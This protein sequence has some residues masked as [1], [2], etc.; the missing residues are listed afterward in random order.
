MK[1]TGLLTIFSAIF[2]LSAC[3]SGLGLSP[4]VDSSEQPPLSNVPSSNG[5][6]SSSTAYGSEEGEDSDNED[7]T[8]DF[9]LPVASENAEYDS[10]QDISID[11]TNKSITNNNGFVVFEE[12]ALYI[13]AGGSYSMS[14]TFVGR[15]VI[16][17][18]DTEVEISLN[19]VD[20]SSDSYCPFLGYGLSKLSI[21]AKKGSENKITDSRTVEGSFN[22]AIYCDSDLDIKGKG[23][24]II[25][26]SLNNG[27]HTKDDLEIKNLSLEVT[28]VNNAIK[29]NDSLTIENATIKAISTSGDALKTKNSDVSKKGNQRGTIS[30]SG[31]SLDL[32]AAT[33]GID[34]AY[35]V[36]IANDPVIN[37]HTD[38]FSEYSNYVSDVSNSTFYLRINGEASN[39]VL[40]VY[41]EDG[42]SKTLSQKSSNSDRGRT[43]LS[44]DMPSDAASFKVALTLNGISYETDVMSVNKNY[45]CLSIIVRNGRITTNYSTYSVSPGPG[46]SGGG[47]S[48]GNQNKSDYSSKGIKADNEIN[49]SGGDI[50]IESHDDAIHAN[51]DVAL[52]NGSNGLGNVAISGGNLSLKSDDDGV[53][54]D[55]KLDI[56]GGTVKV[57]SSYEGLEGNIVTIDGGLSEIKSSDDGINATENSDTPYIHFKSGTV[58]LNADGD[59]IDSNGYIDMS[60]GNVIALGPSNG[61]NGVLDFDRSFTMSGGN[62]L[63]I[64]ASGMNQKP[65]LA[66]GVGGSSVSRVDVSN[67][68]V[69]LNVDSK[70]VLELY[71]S[72]TNMN[73]IVYAGYGSSVTYNSSSTSSFDGGAYAVATDI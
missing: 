70:I 7:A 67:K 27:I 13:M 65:S 69:T 8:V 25:V 22:A 60:G 36:I 68:Y 53:H 54:A 45:D 44:Y 43:Y 17:S 29:G 14:G 31:G 61:G 52:E 23:K 39:V 3:N 21:S 5:G 19:G 56:T 28:A 58:Y 30:I 48:E 1:K 37:I 38:S 51:G 12:D 33:D 40:T 4:A 71:A 24:L 16:S 11:L 46:G 2:I 63:A 32:Y 55:Y 66:S 26:S 34:A 59:G 72:K 47:P 64:G 35:D 73:Y 41:L 15:I 62:L 42:S 6:V 10:T 20:I 49:I 57:L 18:S 9:S 50:V